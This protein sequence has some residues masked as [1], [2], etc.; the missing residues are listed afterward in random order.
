MEGGKNFK[1]NE[2]PTEF[3]RRLF[4]KILIPSLLILE[5]KNS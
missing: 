5:S 1:K 3:S 2:I 4:S